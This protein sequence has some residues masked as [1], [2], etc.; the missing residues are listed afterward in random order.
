MKY[1]IK[2]DYYM[3]NEEKGMYTEELYLGIEG[4][5][6]LFVFDDQITE[7]TKIF[8]SAR[9]AGEYIDARDSLN[10]DAIRCSFESVKIVEVKENDWNN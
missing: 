7:R 4:P 2:A 9:E 8:N 6:K 10:N 5:H 1:A 3:W